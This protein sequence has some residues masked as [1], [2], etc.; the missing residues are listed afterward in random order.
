[1]RAIEFKKWDGVGAVEDFKTILDRY[2]DSE[3][4]ELFA[5]EKI[6]KLNIRF[7]EIYHRC[8]NSEW[9][10]FKEFLSKQEVPIIVN[11]WWQFWER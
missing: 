8:S 1:M 2:A 4:V 10:E 6:I 5:K 7:G 3:R 9:D 11:K